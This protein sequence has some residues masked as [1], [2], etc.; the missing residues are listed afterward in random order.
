MVCPVWIRRCALRLTANENCLS[1]TLQW[2]DLSPVWMPMC[3]SVK[4]N[5]LSH[6]LQG[7]GFSPIWIRRCFLRHPWFENCLPH[8]LSWYVFFPLW[9]LRCECR[10]HFLL[11]F[12][13]NYLSYTLSWCDCSHVWMRR[14]LAKH[15][16]KEK[17]SYRIHCS[18]MFFFFCMGANMYVQMSFPWKHLASYIT[19]IFFFLLCGCNGVCLVVLFVEAY[20]RIHYNNMFLSGMTR[21]VCSDLHPMYDVCLGHP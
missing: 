21:M 10:W 19:M 15:P 11:V 4:K 1:H 20:C 6:T 3:Q 7:Y 14:C 9:M 12:W 18:D 17:K 16:L 8:N 13:V 2:N 5:F